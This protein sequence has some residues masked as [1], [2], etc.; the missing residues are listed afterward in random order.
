MWKPQ[1]LYGQ[2]FRSRFLQPL[3]HKNQMGRL[4]I[5]HT[6]REAMSTPH[7]TALR[8]EELE[9]KQIK[10]HATPL[11]TDHTTS[12]GFYANVAINVMANGAIA[13]SMKPLRKAVISVS[14]PQ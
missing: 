5:M 10:F 1:R 11:T 9:N 8:P 14:E 12:A 6:S 2:C 13:L 4:G 3:S 7:R